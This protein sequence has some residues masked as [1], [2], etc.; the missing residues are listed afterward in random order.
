MEKSF[1]TLE[2]LYDYIRP[3]LYSKKEELN[4]LGLDYAKEEDIW[5]Y[6]S[7]HDWSKSRDLSIFDMVSDIMN[8]DKDKLESY[9]LNMFKNTNRELIKGDNDIL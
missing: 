8:L 7:E 5:N 1:K 4:K 2:E 9:L 6:L 3:A